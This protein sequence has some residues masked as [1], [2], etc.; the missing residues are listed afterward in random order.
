MQKR[1][2][3][4]FCDGMVGYASIFFLLFI[5]AYLI[6]PFIIS[7]ETPRRLN[8]LSMKKQGIDQTELLSILL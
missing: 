4:F 6:T 1:P 3:A 5:F 8:F 7:S 2:G